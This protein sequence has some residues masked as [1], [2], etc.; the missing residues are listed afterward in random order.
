MELR[1]PE[2]ELLT[3]LKA[4]FGGQGRRAVGFLLTAQE[5]LCSELQSAP[6]LGEAI[7]Y[8]LRE[9]MQAILTSAD[10]GGDDGGRWRK[11]SCEVVDS[12]TQYKLADS[13]PGNDGKGALD[14]LLG[15]VDDL[16][17]FHSQEE[18]IH[19]RRLIAVILNRTGLQLSAGTAPVREYQL[20]LDELNNGLHGNLSVAD[21]Y[22]LWPRCLDILRK[23]FLP[24]E[25]RHAELE[26]LARVGSPSP[27]DVE[28]LVQLLVTPKHLQYF[29]SKVT[30][31][32]WLDM[33][34]S[35]PGTLDPPETAQAWPVLYGRNGTWHLAP[36]RL[37]WP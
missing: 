29:L 33:L 7:A 10:G 15:R 12:A 9:A 4:E 37:A 17:R 11:V 34:L 8:C 25:M 19:E 32:G 20:L 27:N 13:F 30:S 14:D 22:E 16:E 1:R 26:A 5:L 24:P 31:P 6:R 3:H 35:R 21:A 2:P 23:L 28:A 18:R 36:F